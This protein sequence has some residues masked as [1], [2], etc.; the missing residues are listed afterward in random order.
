[1]DEAMTVTVADMVI[2]DLT[3]MYSDQPSFNDKK[4][5]V[6]VNKVVE[7]VIKARRYREEEYSDEQI[8][9]DLYNYRTQIYNLS[10]YDFVTLG[11]AHQSSHS[12]NSVNHSWI[13]RSSLFA[14]IIPLSHLSGRIK[15][16]IKPEKEKDTEE[17]PEKQPEEE[18]PEEDAEEDAEE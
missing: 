11:A 9:A 15:K 1:M 16:N 6:I 7:E 13:G 2:S 3:I 10:E 5:A 17:V 18:I 14:G 12:E 8:E 4:L